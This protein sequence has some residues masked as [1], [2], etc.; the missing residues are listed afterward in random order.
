M[1]GKLWSRV[2]RAV[3]EVE[4]PSSSRW[5]RFSDQVIVVVYLLAVANDR[6]VCWACRPESWNGLKRPE[7][8]PSQPTMSRRLRSPRVQA[9][10]DK[11]E[12]E[13]KALQKID[14][15]VGAV[16]GRP[17]TINPYSKDRDAR[18]GYAIRGFGFG[19]KLHMVWCR[20][21][22]PL[23][24]ELLPLN[25]SE[26]RVAAE[27][28]LPRLPRATGKRYL[29][30]DCAYD[31]NPLHA[32]AAERGYQ[33]LAPPKRSG[34][35]LGHRPHHPARLIALAQLKTAYGS[36]LYKR[37]GMIE[38]FF[39]NWAIRDIGLDT[40]PAHVRRLHRIKQ[41]V[42]AK[43]IL[44]GFHILHRRNPLAHAA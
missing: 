5:Q 26:P 36:R 12:A 25:A 28:L 18:W 41:F 42:Q 10:A 27:Q 44:N 31:T 13:L 34:N 37:R 6:P 17:L 33:L 43:I 7:H 8:L 29:L 19:Y 35:N 16:D 22:V 4:H 9:L 30:G 2:Y 1:D 24:W 21:L 15:R 32:A 23:A 39:A 11:V 3:M 40:L 38:R 20:G 14:E